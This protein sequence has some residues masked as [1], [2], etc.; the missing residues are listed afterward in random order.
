MK[1]HDYQ[2]NCKFKKCILH[3]KKLS[4]CNVHVLWTCIDCE[5]QINVSKNYVYQ[6]TVSLERVF[7]DASTR[8][9]SAKFCN[10]LPSIGYANI[11]PSLELNDD[12]L[13]LKFLGNQKNLKTSDQVPNQPLKVV[14]TLPGEKK[15]TS[16]RAQSPS[17]LRRCLVVLC[18]MFN[19]SKVLRS[20]KGK[21]S[22]KKLNK[23]ERTHLPLASGKSLLQKTAKI[24]N[25]SFFSWIFISILR[26]SFKVKPFVNFQLACVMI[27]HMTWLSN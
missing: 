23:L 4:I 14:L 3:V 6:A 19:L 11:L 1:R 13:A 22:R 20:L 9:S 10:R 21:E 17:C 2:L 24:L 12:N 5:I 7:I 25:K 18:M 15:L 26:T 27:G 8:G 16:T